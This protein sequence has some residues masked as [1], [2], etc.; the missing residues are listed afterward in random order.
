MS[1]E[2]LKAPKSNRTVQRTSFRL[3]DEAHKAI[4]AI[5]KLEKF[6]IAH[7]IDEVMQIAE[8]LE[9]MGESW[10]VGD[11]KVS[12]KSVRKTYAVFRH[13]LRK[14]EKR[15]ITE[16]TSRDLLLEF[17]VLAIEPM[18]THEDSLRARKYLEV[19]EKYIRPLWKEMEVV[20]SK[21]TRQ[22]DAHDPL[23]E[24]YQSQM[25]KFGRF[26]GFI[27]EFLSED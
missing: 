4:K 9:K 15:A 11:W 7:A 3:S 13:T 22:F 19:Y 16:N 20:N 18:L 12:G 24:K 8:E 2:N 25:K 17:L 23:L 14:M 21:L 5:A 6:N 10:H 27:K 26:I 1:L